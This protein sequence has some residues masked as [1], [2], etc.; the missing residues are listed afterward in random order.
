MD[1]GHEIAQRLQCS[2]ET[3]AALLE[4][5]VRDIRRKT[6]QGETARL[7][8]IGA[9]EA[10]G[11]GLI[12]EPDAGLA[13][14]VNAPFAGLPAIPLAAPAPIPRKTDE[15]PQGGRSAPA[16]GDLPSARRQT[17]RTRARSR[18]RARWIIGIGL[19]IVAAGAWLLLA[20]R[21]GSPGA[22]SERPSA[23][24]TSASA[25][26]ETPASSLQETAPPSTA[27][28]P[29]ETDQPASKARERIAAPDTLAAATGTTDP[30]AAR[31]YADDPLRGAEPIDRALGG[32]TIVV[33][34]ETNE[35]RARAWA[36]GWR[37]QGFRTTV[38]PH[39]QDGVT[40]YRVGV[41]Q[42]ALL[43]EAA[44]VRDALMGNPWPQGAW[45]LRI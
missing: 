14:I 18:A 20:D 6:A 38:L 37:K 40:L 39:A 11:E 36:E 41:G 21:T 1:L 5:I 31:P 30:L 23:S 27:L 29:A 26:Q 8:N 16:R 34:S 10:R 3:A 28:A 45:V 13:E 22:Q 43:E 42:F 12:F 2:P 25:P 9:F 19:A 35:Q 32:Y 24:A 4:E 44:R 17:L 33:A 7:R 15:A